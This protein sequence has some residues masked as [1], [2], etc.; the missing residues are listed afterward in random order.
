MT[1]YEII[2]D[3]QRG[4]AVLWNVVFDVAFGPV[5][6]CTRYLD[7][8]QVAQSYLDWCQA[9]GREPDSAL[10]VHEWRTQPEALPEDQRHQIVPRKGHAA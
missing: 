10:S 5:F 8:R 4:H 7:A 6:R 9:H 2:H 1:H 3:E